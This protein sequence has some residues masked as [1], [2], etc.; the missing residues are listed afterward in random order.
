MNDTDINKI[1]WSFWAISIFMLLWNVMGSMNFL[2]QINADIETLATLPETHRAIIEGRPIWATG[3]FAVGVIVGSLGCLLLLFK[4]S[5]A[6][7]LF[8]AS[9]LGIIVTMIHTIKVSS[10]IIEFSF[11]EIIIMIALPLVVAVF[12]IWYTKMVE[13]KGWIA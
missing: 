13:R 4:K 8:I 2:W 11:F 5:A 7:Y 1:H 6:V 9:L 3:G 12:L 10:M